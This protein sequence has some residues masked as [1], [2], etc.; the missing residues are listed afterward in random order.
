[1]HLA[2]ID[3]FHVGWSRHPQSEASEATEASSEDTGP[4][5]V[6]SPAYGCAKPQVGSDGYE[7]YGYHP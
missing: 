3:K 1:M 2:L 4:T 6:S 7:A 5:L